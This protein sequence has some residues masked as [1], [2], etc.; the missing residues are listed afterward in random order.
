MKLSVI[1]VNYNVKYFL[2]HCLL[3]VLKALEKID[4]EIIVVD[5]NSVDGS[6]EMLRKKFPSVKLIEND[7]NEGFAKA[8]NKGIRQ[9]KG[10]YILLL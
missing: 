4:G 6:V 8:N 2:E 5:N 1:I 10:E 7:A 9:S 3:S